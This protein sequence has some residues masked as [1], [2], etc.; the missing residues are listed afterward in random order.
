MCILAASWVFYVEGCWN[1]SSFG[2]KIDQRLK[3]WV[4]CKDWVSLTIRFLSGKHDDSASIVYY[5]WYISM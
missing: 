2:A 1:F 4:K 5:T 3:G